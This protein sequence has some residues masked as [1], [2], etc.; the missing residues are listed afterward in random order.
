L[1]IV[2]DVSGR[3]DAER[4]QEA[5]QLP[6]VELFLVQRDVIE[7]GLADAG[8]LFTE[9]GIN[10]HL[11][12]ICGRDDLEAQTEIRITSLAGANDRAVSDVTLSGDTNTVAR[13]GEFGG[14]PGHFARVHGNG[15]RHMQNSPFAS[16]L[17]A[18]MRASLY[19]VILD[20]RLN[21]GIQK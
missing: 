11:A 2:R 21:V 15:N 18:L 13:S 12:A 10:H 5:A 7:E 4:L 3:V 6:H 19:A 8:H 14:G 1:S 20:I 17:M 9:A 16:Y